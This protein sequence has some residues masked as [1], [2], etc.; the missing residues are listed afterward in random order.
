M[1]KEKIGLVYHKKRIEIPVNKVSGL[2][3]FRGLMFRRRKNAKA[4]L[5]EFEKP[6]NLKIHS[7]FVFFPFLAIWIDEKNKILK[8]KIVKPWEIY[9]SPS[10]KFKK[11]IEIPIN[12]L[13]RNILKVLVG[14]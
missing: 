2:E 10:V 7:F 8:K 12:S 13:Y 1:K 4:L 6:T 5:F 3:I 11:L 14:S 9:V